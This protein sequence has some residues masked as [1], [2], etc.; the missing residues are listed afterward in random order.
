MSSQQDNVGIRQGPLR[1]T[2][3]GQRRLFNNL[4]NFPLL[5]NLSPSIKLKIYP[6]EIKHFQVTKIHL[7]IL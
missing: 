3:R 2:L 5:F 6:N 1:E 4:P 7:Y